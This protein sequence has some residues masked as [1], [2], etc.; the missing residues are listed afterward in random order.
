MNVGDDYSSGVDAH[1]IEAI[2]QGRPE[3]QE[4]L[5]K[6][7]APALLSYI[8]R[9]V[10]NL[11]DAEEILNDVL[12]TAITKIDSFDVSKSQSREPLRAWVYTITKNKI[13]DHLRKRK[14]MKEQLAEAGIQAVVSLTD[15]D[16]AEEV[17]SVEPSPST[18]KSRALTKALQNLPERDGFV[19]ECIS[20]KVKPA[21]I[22]VYLGLKPETV[23]IHIYRAKQ[24]LLKELHKYPEF[25]DFF[26]P[27]R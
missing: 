9:S 15:R 18:A 27:K 10:G 16:V 23:R 19:L 1:L 26:Q 3:A 22:A 20:N 13:R 6:H 7:Y 17:S 5:Y 24:R 11:E 25:D 2:K 12:Y 4:W 21:E 8:K 14:R